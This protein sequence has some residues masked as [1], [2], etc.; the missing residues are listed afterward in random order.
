MQPNS[1]TC[2]RTLRCSLLEIL[3]QDNG[4]TVPA[5]VKGHRSVYKMGP[6]EVNTSRTS[7]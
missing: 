1:S 3:V 4:C 6:A 7:L 5:Q 2:A